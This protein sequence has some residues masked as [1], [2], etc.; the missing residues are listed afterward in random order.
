MP[1]PSLLLEVAFRVW[2]FGEGGE[3]ACFRR[4]L[5][6]LTDKPVTKTLAQHTLNPKTLKPQSPKPLSPNP[7]TKH[8]AIMSGLKTKDLVMQP[9]EVRRV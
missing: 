8:N 3:R 2:G 5:I 9:V 7:N 1:T 4:S 6:K